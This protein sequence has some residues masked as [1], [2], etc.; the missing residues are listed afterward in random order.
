MTVPNAATAQIN[1]SMAKP[2]K[3]INPARISWG[4]TWLIVLPSFYPRLIGSANHEICGERAYC[5][6]V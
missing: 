5:Y 1:A 4:I 3:S 6:V 2:T